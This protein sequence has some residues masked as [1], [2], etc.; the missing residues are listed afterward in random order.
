MFQL[1][2]KTFGR[3]QQLQ[4]LPT[5]RLHKKVGMNR[6]WS[7]WEAEG[8]SSFFYLFTGENYSVDLSEGW[9]ILNIPMMQQSGSV[10]AP[11]L[12]VNYGTGFSK[13]HSFDLR[14]LC[15]PGGIKGAVRFGHRVFK[16][17]FDPCVEICEFT[18]GN[19]SIR[20]SS[21]LEAALSMYGSLVKRKWQ[22][23]KLAYQ[24]LSEYREGGARRAGDWL[25][26]RYMPTAQEVV[27]SQAKNARAKRRET[28]SASDWKAMCTASELFSQKPLI[29]TI[30][31][32]YDPSEQPLRQC[33]ES[34]QR[35][36]YPYWELCVIDNASVSEHIRAVLM[37]YGF[38]D[39]RIRIVRSD[40]YASMAEA[41]DTALA[42]ASGKWVT[43]LGHADELS[44]S[45][46]FLVVKKINE[47]QG[48]EVLYSDEDRTD[49]APSL[50]QRF[51][52]RRNPGL[53]WKAI[54]RLGVYQTLRVRELGGLEAIGARSRNADMVLR[55]VEGLQP[56]Y[57][58]H[59]PGAVYYR[60]AE[61]G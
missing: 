5:H 46:F 41:L 14:H 15:T 47:C 57:V 10:I 35:Q 52:P 3:R 58:A 61:A 55:C 33:I 22:P 37:Q 56:K 32:V 59:I 19:I 44:P 24:L 42:A 20:R 43:L 21:K 7:A 50:C 60:H 1:R 49:Q 9:Y 54:R 16:L 30:L 28:L 34:V 27:H 38:R 26:E 6:N 13:L 29:S 45:A 17:R 18:L 31:P 4:L 51:D 48:V 12:Y 36:A 2:L 53:Q 39:P 23:A 8:G 11:R 40:S 25:Y